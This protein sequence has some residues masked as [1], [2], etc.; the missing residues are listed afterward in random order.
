M[1][2]ALRK[3]Y[4]SKPVELKR[5]RLDPDCQPR[6]AIDSALVAEYR[7]KL[8]DGAIFDNIDV[9][10][11][12]SD[13][14]CAD[15]FHRAMCYQAANRSHI[16]A[17][18]HK[19]GKRDA[20]L[21]AVGANEAHGL[22]R[23]NADKRRAVEMLLSDEEWRAWSDRQIADQCGVSHTF[24]ALV[25]KETQPAQVATVA[26]CPPKRKGADGKSYPATQPDS[27]KLAK[28]NGVETVD[29]PDIARLRKAG[30]IPADAVVTIEG[31]APAEH[32]QVDDEERAAIASDDKSDA[33]WLVELPLSR[34]LSGHQLRQFHRDALLYRRM[35]P[36]RR[37]YVHAFNREAKALSR[38]YQGVPTGDYEVLTSWWV[39]L[40]H[41][42]DW[43]VCV[44]PEH[45]GCDG[46]G[47]IGVIGQCP[48]CKGRGYRVRTHD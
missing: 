17:N 8:E 36:A 25:R 19:G 28:V 15:G 11:D 2:V 1:S 9:Y 40:E 13:Y 20:I 3:Q 4:E 37:T 22:K 27:P 5:L 42:K 16:P 6:V 14:W 18:V 41:P 43:R 31:E 21:H 45:G 26:T 44:K 46:K 10:F 48:T 34:V 7:Q 24:V 12:G 47:I 38:R 23:S 32:D 35:E 30:A 33:D 39:R 29:P